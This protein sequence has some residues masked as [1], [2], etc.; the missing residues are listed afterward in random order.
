MNRKIDIR[1]NCG[2]HVVDKTECIKEDRENRGDMRKS[3]HVV[4]TDMARAPIA[5]S[6]DYKRQHK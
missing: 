5:K 6:L 4:D 1:I 3:R 2:E